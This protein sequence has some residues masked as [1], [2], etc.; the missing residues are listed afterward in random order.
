MSR[1]TA[2][3]KGWFYN[4]DRNY[5]L[6]ELLIFFI[7]GITAFPIFLKF[8]LID[9]DNYSNVKSYYATAAI[10]E[11]KFKQE[12]LRNDLIELRERLLNYTSGFSRI[13]YCETEEEAYR[14][15][16][17][18]EA[19]FPGDIGVLLIDKSTGRSFSNRNWFEDYPYNELTPKEALTKLSK[20]DDVT[21]YNSKDITHYKSPNGYYN[22]A[23]N[24]PNP[25]IEEIY[26][27][28]GTRYNYISNNITSRFYSSVPLIIIFSIIFLKHIVCIKKISFK[29]YMLKF[30]NTLIM[31]LYRCLKFLFTNMGLILKRIFYDKTLMFLV[32]F[33]II[34]TPLSIIFSSTVY[35]LRLPSY[36]GP[37]IVGTVIIIIINILIRFLEGIN[38]SEKLL[39]YL[40][41]IE[42]GDIDVTINADNLGNFKKLGIALNKLKINYSNK[43]EAGIKNEKLKTELI[44]NVSHDLKTPLTSIVNYVDILK[45]ETLN[46]DEI[47]DYISI[48]DNKATKLQKLVEDLF[49]MSKMTSGQIILDKTT[50]DMVELVYQS[51]GELAFLGE[52]KHLSFK[53]IGEKNCPINV[54]GARMSRV[55]DNLI[56]NA[57]KYSLENSRVYLCVTSSDTECIVE[58]K[59][60][61]KY[62]LDFDENEILERFVRGEKSRNSSIAGSGLGLAISKTIVELHNGTIKIKCDG[63]LFKV[64]I[65]LPK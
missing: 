59:N 35:S 27:I 43:I 55:M 12:M 13:L 53:V 52:D 14:I 10:N 38:N 44:T 37:L 32:I 42:A 63:D 15:Q 51:L 22:G 40:T 50:V 23:Y 2:L 41:K 11:N 25:D 61:S 48:L 4:Y 5:I 33:W 28:R 16:K 20:E 31:R 65:K 54:D 62:D 24:P 26:F 57:I 6:T 47:R 7:I 64:I 34:Y 1:L 29:F 3:I 45:D 58:V 36:T 60:I 8:T 19:M 30:K 39:K 49:E 56:C 21:L 17:D 9:Y 18:L 46:K